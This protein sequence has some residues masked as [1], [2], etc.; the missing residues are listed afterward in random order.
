ML[1]NVDI[2]VVSVCTPDLYH[3]QCLRDL[4]GRVRGIFLEK[5][6]C[7][8]SEIEGAGA[9][10][11][12]V[13]EMKTCIRVNYY[14]THEPLFRK[15][16]DYLSEQENFYLSVKYSG[17]FEAVGSHALNLLVFLNPKIQCTKSFRFNHKEGDGVS[18]LFEFEEKGLAELIYCGPRHNLIFELDVVG[19]DRRILLEKNFSSLRLFE[20]RPSARYEGFN[21]IELSGEETLLSNTNRFTLHL[22]ALAEEVRSNQP[23]Y[24]NWDEALKTQKLMAQISQ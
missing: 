18:A 5:P 8:V 21:E 14:K 16:I 2:D 13:K 9:L 20:Y 19:R 7:G 1:D 15:A 17:P 12:Q 11:S 3:L 4:V 22:K 6:V 10:I 24:S 23:D